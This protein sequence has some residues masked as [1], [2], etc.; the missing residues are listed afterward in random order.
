M[1]KYFY[2]VKVIWVCIVNLEGRFLLREIIEVG[3]RRDIIFCKV[4]SKVGKKYGM[5][6]LDIGLENMKLREVE[7]RMR[8]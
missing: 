8:C 7:K 5:L 6:G 3:F 1:D 2:G 4:E